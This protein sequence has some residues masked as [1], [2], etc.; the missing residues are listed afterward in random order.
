M[1]CLAWEMVELEFVRQP[2]SRAWASR[3]SMEPAGAHGEQ[4]L[5]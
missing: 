1:K 4:T 3:C 5:Y 2:E